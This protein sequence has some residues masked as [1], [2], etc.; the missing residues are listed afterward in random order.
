MFGRAL[1]WFRPDFLRIGFKNFEDDAVE[2]VAS[3][4]PENHISAYD[5][6]LYIVIDADAVNCSISQ[7]W[8]LHFNQDQFSRDVMSLGLGLLESTFLSIRT[9]IKYGEAN[10][11]S[12]TTG[13]CWLILFVAFTF[14]GPVVL[15]YLLFRH[16][17]W[18]QPRRNKLAL[19]AYLFKLSTYIILLIEKPLFLTFQP[20]TSPQT[21]KSA[22]FQLIFPPL[23]LIRTTMFLIIPV[24]SWS[25][26]TIVGNSMLVYNSWSLCLDE[27]ASIP[28][29]GLWYTKL[30]TDVEGFIYTWLPLPAIRAGR[31]SSLLAS[32]LTDTG[33]CIATKSWLQVSLIL[34][35]FCS[36]NA[37]SW[38]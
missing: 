12:L 23:Y 31:F 7:A 15:S 34:R 21:A 14:L 19:I 32:G 11:Y 25:P 27:L 8:N 6:F 36:I 37:V 29:Q 4:R 35:Y 33:A 5:I 22:A 26:L 24:K 30:I 20:L 3:L 38:S 18:F 1:A 28:G 17:K 10:T 2:E 9:I 13:L 16:R